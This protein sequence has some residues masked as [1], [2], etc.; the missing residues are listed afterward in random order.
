MHRFF[1]P[2]EECRAPVL[3]L[4][5][6][7]A[8]HALHVVRVR[9]N[10]RVS[11]LDGD[12]AEYLCE[13]KDPRR[14]EVE[15]K[16]LEKMST[17]P[18]PWKITLA[19]ALPKGKLIESIIQKATELGVA[20]IVPLLAERVVSQ[21]NDECGLE[22]QRK[23]Q[24]VAIEAIKQCGS[25]WLPRI[26]KP[27]TP[28]QFLRRKEEFD[29]SLVGSLQPG[30]RHPREFFSEFQTQHHRRP[31]SVSIWVGPEGDFTPAELEAIQTAGAKPI[32]LGRLVL[33]VETAAICCLAA[34]N[35]ELA[36]P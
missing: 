8:H 26:E 28:D 10:D 9:H 35:Y 30:S 3:L 7:E 32:T 5:D 19:Q 27:M 36:S 24:S 12:G 17:P 25:P 31:A 20:R 15:L 21:L 1:L 29:L 2:P 18:L 11:I 33:R 23:W 34:I 14:S 4:H 22:K 13:V 16:V 6:A